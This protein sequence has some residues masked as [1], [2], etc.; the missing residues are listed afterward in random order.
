M[1][2]LAISLSGIDVLDLLSAPSEGHAGRVV[3][4]RKLPSVGDHGVEIRVTLNIARNMIVVLNKLVQG[5]LVI[6]FRTS[7]TVMVSL[8]SFHEFYQDLFLSSLT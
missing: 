8:E 4:T 1:V 3:P 6:R 7:F 2:I 5:N